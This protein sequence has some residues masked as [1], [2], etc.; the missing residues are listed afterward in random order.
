MN[1]NT[2]KNKQSTG[3]SSRR[4]VAYL[5]ILGTAQLHLRNPC[6]I[7]WWS[8][9]FPGLG[10]ILLAKYLRGFVLFVWEVVINVNAHINLA[11][12]YTFTGRYQL[13]KEVLDTRWLLL[14]N[15]VYIFAIWDSYRTTVDLNN[16]YILA[17][18]EDAE[19]Q[20]FRINSLEINYLDKRHPWVAAFWSLLMPGVGQLYLHRLVNA[21]FT[22]TWWIAILYFSNALPAIHLTFLGEFEQAKNVLNEH[23]TLNISSVYL[24]GMYD[25]YINTVENNK[26]FD[27]EQAKFLKKNYQNSGFCIPGKIN[28]ARGDK[29]YIVSTFEHTIYLEK[30]ITAIEKN[31]IGKEAI[32]AV[33]MD[34]R[35]E[36]RKFFDT[37]H[38]SDGLSLI[39]LAT[40]LG[41]ILML[42]GTIYGFI[43]KLGPIFWGLAGLVTGFAIGLIIKLLLLR[44][45]NDN[46][47]NYKKAP[48]VVLIIDCSEEKSEMVKDTLWNHNALGVSKLELS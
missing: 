42:F 4:Q 2:S 29:V 28:S 45:Y 11:I 21:L 24:F 34:K 32:L 35:K 19:I 31:G 47:Q 3:S 6:V 37:I 44:K 43:L 41:T 15:A 13:A 22:L 9:A 18:R 23:W 39:D 30:A 46:R 20:A 7:A 1:R 27:W 33:P 10:H 17:E 26:L 38:Q 40:I 5:G 14:Y 36:K 48:E 16:N 12:L 25:A 8:A